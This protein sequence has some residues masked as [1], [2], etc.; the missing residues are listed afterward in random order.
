MRIARYWSSFIS[1]SQFQS[2]KKLWSVDKFCIGEFLPLKYLD[3]CSINY[4]NTAMEFV[5][6]SSLTYLFVR[7]Q[8]IR[9][10]HSLWSQPITQTLT[11]E[12]RAAKAM[13]HVEQASLLGESNKLF[14]GLFTS[15][16]GPQSD[17]MREGE[18]SEND[19]RNWLKG[20]R[21]SG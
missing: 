15:A 8:L 21:D 16:D 1:S 9:S 7:V 2:K 5:K 12:I 11:S 6:Y 18:S 14:K 4:G 13:N 10:I 20:I 17:T 3:P 19:I